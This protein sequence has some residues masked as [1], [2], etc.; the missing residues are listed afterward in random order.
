[1]LCQTCCHTFGNSEKKPFQSR[2]FQNVCLNFFII[3]HKMVF[4]RI[5]AHFSNNIRFK[6]NFYSIKSIQ[7]YLAAVWICMA[8]KRSIWHTQCKK[9]KKCKKPIKL[10]KWNHK[11]RKHY[12]RANKKTANSIQF[13][14]SNAKQKRDTKSTHS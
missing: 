8:K 10:W 12:Y 1:M 5:S 2:T 9:K 14:M 3:F 13:E 7:I 6:W 11:Q 4:Q